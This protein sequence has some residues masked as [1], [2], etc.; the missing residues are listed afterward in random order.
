LAEITLSVVDLK[1]RLAK[2]PDDCR[3][4][5]FRNPIQVLVTV[6]E[7]AGSGSFDVAQKTVETLVDFITALINAAWRIVGHERSDL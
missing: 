1:D 3:V 7:I 4:T 5:D 2:N 6:D